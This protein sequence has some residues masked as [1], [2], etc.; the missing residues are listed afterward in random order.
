MSF[1][2]I[3]QRKIEASR[4]GHAPRAAAAAAREAR[5]RVEAAPLIAVIEAMRDT[6]SADPMFANAM[7]RPGLG[8]ELHDDPSRTGGR[9]RLEGRA[10]EFVFT[11]G[12][13]GKVRLSIYPG[14]AVIADLDC[15]EVRYTPAIPV[16]GNIARLDEFMALVQDHIAD[17]MADVALSG[18]AHVLQPTNAADVDFRGLTRF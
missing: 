8:L 12:R 6:L 9:L 7:G 3:V 18:A 10:A 16:E 14:L 17:F 5:L 1:T 4:A 15:P 13:E 11:L 2:D